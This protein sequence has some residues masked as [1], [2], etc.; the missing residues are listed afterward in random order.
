M[1]FQYFSKAEVNLIKKNVFDALNGGW[2]E[3]D[4]NFP[5]SGYENSVEP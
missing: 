3:V 2:G 5:P 4:L 1:I